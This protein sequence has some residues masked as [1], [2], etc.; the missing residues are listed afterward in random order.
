MVI[1]LVPVRVLAQRKEELTLNLERNSTPPWLCLLIPRCHN[2]LDCP[3][4][5]VIMW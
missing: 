3:F 4:L 1:D 2:W 5:S